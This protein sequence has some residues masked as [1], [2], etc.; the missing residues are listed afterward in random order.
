M[1][2]KPNRYSDLIQRVLNSSTVKDANFRSSTN[3]QD[4]LAQLRQTRFDLVVVDMLLPETAWSEQIDEGG[5]VL[6]EY[7]QEDD[8]IKLPAYLVGITAAAEVSPRVEKIFAS[9]PWQLLRTAK[10]GG[11]WEEQLERLI[12]HAYLNETRTQQVAYE[13][14]VCIITALRTPEFEA[15]RDTA[16]R[17][18]ESVPIDPT[19]FATIG[20]LQ[21]PKGPL[22]VVAASCLR[23]GSTES[24][25]LS[26][27]LIERFRPRMLVMIGICAGYEPNVDYGDP[28]LA[29]PAWDY[30]CAKISDDGNGHREITHAPDYIAVDREVV[31]KFEQLKQDRAFFQKLHEQWRGEKPRSLFPTLHIG[32]SATGPA[33][34]ADASVFQEIRSKQNRQTIGLEMEA[35]GVYCAARMAC[36]PRP[37]SFSV[38]SVCDFGSFLKDDKY[39]AYAAYTSASVAT[40]FLMRYGRDVVDSM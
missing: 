30:T 16:L 7:I 36:R 29:T 4:G 35:Y 26:Y 13:T 10:G 32:P 18:E 38:K 37:V 22:S 24:A 14:D 25:L 11:A 5:A 15:L 2:D 33:V 12:T 1:D 20:S 23:M 6:L 8:D 28:I 9:N 3:V 39:Q 31:A 34:I 19:S 21:T 27:K 40:E 17:L